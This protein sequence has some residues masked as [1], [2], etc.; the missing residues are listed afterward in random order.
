MPKPIITIPLGGYAPG[1]P[2]F[3]SGMQRAENFMPVFGGLRSIPVPSGSLVSMEVDPGET[4][5]D[6]NDLAAGIET[7]KGGAIVALAQTVSSEGRYADLTSEG[8][9]PVGTVILAS[10]SFVPIWGTQNRLYVGG[11]WKSQSDVNL[12]LDAYS[13]DW[14]FC[15]FG[16]KV[17][18]ANGGSPL[19]VY[20]LANP[21]SL[22]FVDLITDSD[23]NAPTARHI[24]VVGSHV[25]LANLYLHEA[26]ADGLLVAGTHPQTVW[27]SADEDE[28][29][30]S[31]AYADFDLNT[32]WEH[33]YDI[34]GEITG[35]CGFPDA[36]VILKR[37]GA[38][39]MKLTGG[40]GLFSFN[41]LERG[42][43]CISRRSV[44]AVDMNVF[45][46]AQDGFRVLSGFSSSRPIM[47]ESLRREIFDIRFQSDY[48][49]N[50]ST[51][52]L[53]G[54]TYDA[55]SGC[56]VW[57]FRR[58]SDDLAIGLILN[59]SSGEWSVL[60]DNDEFALLEAIASVAS[61]T[62]LSGTYLL[63]KANAVDLRY[64]K[65]LDG[66]V[67][68]SIDTLEAVAQTKTFVLATDRD[69][70]PAGTMEA[71][72]SRVRPVFRTHRDNDEVPVIPKIVLASASDPDLL[73][74]YA[75][76]VMDPGQGFMLD[77]TNWY[78]VP[79]GQ[80]HGEYFN[81]TLYFPSVRERSLYEV[82]GVQVEYEPTKDS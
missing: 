33:L 19:K 26:M 21:S 18:A 58:A 10:D 13:G 24:G 34:P 29:T 62:F 42:V 40:P 49:V 77:R 78:T 9:S 36:G 6:P 55:S 28:A 27:W 76:T 79:T 38:H 30:Y 43:G 72:I 57:V 67:S 73:A 15:Q 2:S 12:S 31:S 20:N 5:P 8:E 14:S 47:P 65:W 37:Y 75:E 7:N 74:D 41:S 60:R 45:F 32:G 35:F 71:T 16:S 1:A 56:A 17:I 22:G 52:R 39:L 11:S 46:L 3:G 25:V 61:P 44:L 50:L 63:R 64:R 68:D 82:I 51:D 70:S 66:N 59:V 4:T 81:V 80:F 69:A 23:A 48:T 53:I 54:A